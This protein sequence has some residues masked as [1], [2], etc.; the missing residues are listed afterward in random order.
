MTSGKDKPWPPQKHD[1]A[2]RRFFS[3]PEMVE[4][5]VRGFIREDWVKHLDF[6]HMEQ[7]SEVLVGEKYDRRDSDTIWRIRWREPHSDKPP[8]HVVFI[9]EFLSRPDPWAAVRLL[10]YV[11]LFYQRL[12]DNGAVQ[13]GDE[14]PPIVPIVLYNGKAT[15]EAAEEL[16][17]LIAELPGLERFRP[18][19]RY[20]ALDE[21]RFPRSE[22]ET[23]PNRAAALFQLEQSRGPEDILQGMKRLQ[24]ILADPDDRLYSEYLKWLAEIFDSS[25]AP[26]AVVGRIQTLEDFPMLV[27]NILEW[28]ANAQMEGR[29]EGRKEGRQ[30]GRQEGEQ[31]G[32]RKGEL[33]LLRRQLEYKFGALP[34]VTVDRLERADVDQLLEWGKRILTASS[35]DEL[36]VG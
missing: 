17:E 26:A 9:F 36:F 32:I 18:T 27:E 33:T 19:F 12:I 35:L 23:M 31:I 20:V 16:S 22:L 4:D 29:E 6:E 25:A 14:L 24:G 1:R 21:K 15:W 11:A 2:Y 34:E 8:L 3:H 28:K 13:E 30:E 7:A 10:S 5:L